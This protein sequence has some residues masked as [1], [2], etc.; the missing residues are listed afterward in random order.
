MADVP[1]TTPP[2]LWEKLKPLA[3]QHR[4]NPTPAE[5]ALWQRLRRNQLAYHFRRQHTIERF[6]ADFYCAKARPVIEVDGPIHDY[7][8][9]ED[10]IRQV[11][12]ESRG[13]RVLRF[14]NDEVLTNMEGV[15]EIIL[16]ALRSE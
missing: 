1:W 8:P 5:D 4:H 13:L 6:I 9:E 7:T 3:R 10:A 2:E 12:L 11:Y 14:R 15:L 16:S